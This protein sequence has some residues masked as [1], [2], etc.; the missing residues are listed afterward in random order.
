[1]SVPVARWVVTCSVAVTSPR[2]PNWPDVTYHSVPVR[3]AE[4]VVV[5]PSMSKRPALKLKNFDASVVRSR[6]MLMVVTIESTAQKKKNA[7]VSSSSGA[8]SVRLV[9]SVVMSSELIFGM[10]SRSG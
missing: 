8:F 3:N 5:C 9:R 6:T 2:T 4:S 10:W 1:M 7:R